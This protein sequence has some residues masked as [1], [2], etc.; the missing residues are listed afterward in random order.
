[1]KLTRF[2][3]PALMLGVLFCLNSATTFAQGSIA[4]SQQ[5]G[6]GVNT[7]G[8]AIAYA[9]SPGFHIG[10]DFGILSRTGDGG[11]TTINFGP[12]AR[13]LFEGVVNPFVQ[14]GIGLS[15]SGD[16]DAST[17]L[18]AA[19]GLEYF[20]NPSFGVFGGVSVVTIPFQSGVGT[21]IGFARGTL[22]I[23]YWLRR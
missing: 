10:S 5:L 18:Y 8:I 3:F 9:L 12:Y 4:P 17:S 1:M 7:D 23:E 20:I 6:I 22:G 21:A 11:S 2:F 19:G 14:I 13:L 16:S 15:K